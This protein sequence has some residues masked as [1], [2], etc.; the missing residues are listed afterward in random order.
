[1]TNQNLSIYYEGSQYK[2][3]K[4]DIK[5]FAP[6]LFAFGELIEETN[7]VLNNK[8]VKI[9]TYITADFEKKCFKCKLSLKSKMLYWLI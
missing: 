6:S 9:K 4:I 1:M 8:K 5:E 2:D 3:G 7:R